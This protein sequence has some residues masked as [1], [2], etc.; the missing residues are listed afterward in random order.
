MVPARTLNLAIVAAAFAVAGC[1]RE[2]PAP[3]P[4]AVDPAILLAFNADQTAWRAERRAALLGRDG[5]TTLV[6]LHWLE[7]GPHYVGSARDNGVRL[8]VG[9]PQLGMIDVRASGIRFVPDS[10]VGATVDG[11][12][13][14]R[15]VSLRADDDPAGAS[16]I[17]F[18]QGK[19][20]ATVIRRGSRYALRVKHADAKPR[21][22]FAGLDY[23]P[24]GPDWIIRGQYVA[25]PRGHTIE[26][27]NIV[28]TLERLPNPGAVIFD[29][30]GRRVVIEALRGEDGGLFLV[31]ADRTSGHGSYG[32]GRYLDAAA[33]DR[34]G[35][36]LLDFNRAYNPPCAFTLFATCPLPPAGNR[37]DLRVAAGEKAYAGRH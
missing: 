6:G 19:G 27:A 22:E 34:S 28:G 25:H 9:P 35:R 21:T 17:G 33:P 2:A 4:E 24:G 7:P 12:P 10:A 3:T 14:R 36:V 5:W 31:F 8:T 13:A 32:P 16:R 30:D 11:A 37:L 26:I 18:D 23:W 1:T 20:V 29:R 15:P